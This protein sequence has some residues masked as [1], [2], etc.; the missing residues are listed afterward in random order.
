[1]IFRQLSSLRQKHK[2]TCKFSDF[3]TMCEGKKCYL[4]CEEC[5]Y[6]RAFDSGWGYCNALPEPIEVAWCKDV[7]RLF[8][9]I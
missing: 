2:N 3:C 6:Y 1:M 5:L 9:V 7:C 4:T 8:K